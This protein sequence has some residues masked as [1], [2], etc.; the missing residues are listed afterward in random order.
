MWERDDLHLVGQRWAAEDSN[1]LQQFIW[2]LL[3]MFVARSANLP[4]IAALP[5]IGSGGQTFYWRCCGGSGSWSGCG[6][7]MTCHRGT[8]SVGCVTPRVVG[9]QLPLAPPPP[10]LGGLPPTVSCQR[11]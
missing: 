10:P 11:C 2:Q 8:S 5:G 4:A 3:G 9:R 7:T 1:P 6:R